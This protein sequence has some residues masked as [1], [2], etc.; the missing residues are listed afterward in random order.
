M[1]S[2]WARS[3]PVEA[4][5]GPV[6]DRSLV[7]ACALGDRAAL[8]LLFDRFHEPLYRFL[9]RVAGGHAVPPTVNPSGR[10]QVTHTNVL[11]SSRP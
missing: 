11:T 9:F 4:P 1:P 6:S 5:G 2:F 7:S 3:G 8:G 10:G